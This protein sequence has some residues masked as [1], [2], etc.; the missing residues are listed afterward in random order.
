MFALRR[1]RSPYVYGRDISRS[2]SR[3]NDCS[4]FGVNLERLPRPDPDGHA[5]TQLESVGEFN[6]QHQRVLKRII[7]CDGQDQ[8]ATFQVNPQFHT[9]NFA[10]QLFFPV[11]QNV[12][13]KP[14][15]VIGQLRR[16][17]EVDWK[18]RDAVG[19]G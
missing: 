14:G 19:R 18:E 13:R 4:R 16:P 6:G 11:A 8:T 3:S 17:R 1:Q 9:S 2:P 15:T 12:G 10:A 5:S 7:G